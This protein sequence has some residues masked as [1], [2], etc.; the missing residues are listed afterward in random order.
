VNS[1]R[2]LHPTPS[3]G[4]IPAAARLQLPASR[5]ARTPASSSLR[6]LART[7]SRVICCYPDMPKLA[8]AAATHARKALVLSFPNDHWWTRL[9]LTVVNLGFVVFRVQFRVFLHPPKLILAAVERH[10]FTTRSNRRGLVWQVAALDRTDKFRRP[11]GSLGRGLHSEFF[12]MA[13]LA[14]AAVAT[15]PTPL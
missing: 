6:A 2:Y 10:G 8:A 14:P 3:L 4:S 12:R 11:A 13:L 1:T 15:R 7:M 5:K 9:G